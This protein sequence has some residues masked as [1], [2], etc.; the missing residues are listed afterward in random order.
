MLRARILEAEREGS[1]ILWSLL[2]PQLNL[3]LTASS[4]LMFL[5]SAPHSQ[6]LSWIFLGGPEVS[7]PDQNNPE[8]RNWTLCGLV[9]LLPPLLPTNTPILT[10]STMPLRSGLEWG[11]FAIYSDALKEWLWDKAF[12]AQDWLLCPSPASPRAAAAEGRPQ[13]MKDGVTPSQWHVAGTGY[14]IYDA[15]V[16]MAPRHQGKWKRH[17]GLC[18]LN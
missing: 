9:F 7:P 17:L 5:P 8:G 12:K 11:L 14:I 18:W 3:N 13:D 10:P 15:G 4:Y 16:S 2:I 6:S 1:S